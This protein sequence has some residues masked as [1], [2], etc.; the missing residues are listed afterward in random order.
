MCTTGLQI[1]W[2]TVFLVEYFGPILIHTIVV[3]ARPFLYKNAEAWNLS[4]TQWLTYGMIVLHFVKRELETLFVHKFSANTMPA[5]NIFKNSFFY[6][7]V[8]GLMCAYFIYSPTSLAATADKPII[9]LVGTLIYLFGE[10]GNASI[11]LYL[12]GLRSTGGTERKIPVG[13]AFSL[14]TCPNYMF[15]VLSWVGIIV[16]SR[17]WSV[18]FFIAIGA[19]QMFTWAKGKER[20][21][22]K[23]FGDKYKKKRFVMLPGLL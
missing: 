22:R 1:A 13:F 21:Y 18:A 16:A 10:L 17:D 6:W 11:H 23:E 5:Y 12:S 3:A 14:V 4:S 15:E 8:S 2:R 7:A 20:A 19:F 9:D